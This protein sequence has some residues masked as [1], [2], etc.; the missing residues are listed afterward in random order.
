M[1]A[2]RNTHYT[3]RGDGKPHKRWQFFNLVT[4][5]Y[6][7]GWNVVREDTAFP[8]SQRSYVVANPSAE[9]SPVLGYADGADPSTGTWRFYAQDHLGSTG[10][11]YDTAKALQGLYEYEPYGELFAS[12]GTALGNIG[13]S[14]TGKPWDATVGLFHFP[15]RDYD[16]DLGRWPARDGVDLAADGPNMYAY[17]DSSPT[18]HAYEHVS[19]KQSIGASPLRRKRVVGYPVPA[20]MDQDNI[21]CKG[22]RLQLN[23]VTKAPAA[24][25]VQVHEESHR[26]DWFRRYGHDLCK[27]VADYMVIVD[28]Q[29]DYGEFWRRSECK[30]YEKDMRCFGREIARLLRRRPPD[31]EGLELLRNQ[32]NFPERQ[33]TKEHKCAEL[34][35]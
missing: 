12:V 14:F 23:I 8:S 30:S 22:G 2:T 27:G 33:F 11:L 24:V 3:H 7:I 25:C 19:D 17:V 6:D 28:D 31:P 9:V 16:P 5:R 34:G 35:Y 32:R 15:Y 13:P 26:K 10:R 18:T 29:P 4:Y 1:T 20:A 21:H